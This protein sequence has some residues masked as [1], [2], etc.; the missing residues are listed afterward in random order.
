MRDC[1]KDS[2][3]TKEFK[4]KIREP[5]I[6]PLCYLKCPCSFQSLHLDLFQQGIWKNCICLMH[7][8][9]QHWASSCLKSWMTFT[10]STHEVNKC[11]ERWADLLCNEFPGYNIKG[12]FFPCYFKKPGEFLVK[13]AALHGSENSSLVSQWVA[14][15]PRR[16]NKT[17]AKEQRPRPHLKKRS[18]QEG[19]APSI[20]SGKCPELRDS[21]WHPYCDLLSLTFSGHWDSLAPRRLKEMYSSSQAS[22]ASN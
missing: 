5:Q 4:G 22:G 13:I 17:V 1:L 3:T 6:T 18:I 10:H 21:P 8:A 15:K 11:L 14:L 7:I 20:L 12:N 2:N 19:R 9:K 16:A